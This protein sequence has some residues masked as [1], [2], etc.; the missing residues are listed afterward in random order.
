MT[1]IKTKEFSD[2]HENLFVAQTISKKSKYKPTFEFLYNRFNNNGNCITTRMLQEN[3]RIAD[4][5]TAYQI[6]EGFCIVNL[7]KKQKLGSS[8]KYFPSNKEWWD[9]INKSL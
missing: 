4:F 1:L 7:L 5:S 6:L 3:L 2:E 8:V 9:I